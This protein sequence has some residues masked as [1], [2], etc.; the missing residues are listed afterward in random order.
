M[1]MLA[2]WFPARRHGWFLVPCCPPNLARLFASVDRYAAEVGAVGDLLVH[3]PVASRIHRRRVG[4]RGRRRVS[5]DG[6]VSVTV[7]AAPGD[8]RTVWVRRALAGPG[9]GRVPRPG[10]RCGRIAGPGGPVGGLAVVDDRPPGRGRRRVHLRRG[11]VVHCLEGVDH[12]ASTSAT[13]SPTRPA[14]PR[15]RSR[16]ARPP[17]LHHPVGGR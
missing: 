6:V 9:S 3:L 5:A 4:R 15:R 13:W 17:A 12:G 16:C 2:E 10:G 11:P 1:M 14:R 8:D 7:H